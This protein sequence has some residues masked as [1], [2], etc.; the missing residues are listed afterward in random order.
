MRNLLEGESRILGTFD[1]LNTINDR[2]QVMPI[3]LCWFVWFIDKPDPLIVTNGL[4][5]DSC[6]L[7]KAADGYVVI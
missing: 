6:G 7:G 1:E 2:C 4:D 3:A 5:I